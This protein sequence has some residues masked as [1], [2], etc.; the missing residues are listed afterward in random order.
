MAN[1]RRRKM[2]EFERRGVRKA[3]VRARS[4]SVRERTRGGYICACTFKPEPE[5]P[6]PPTSHF[7]LRALQFRSEVSRTESAF[8]ALDRM[9]P[10]HDGRLAQQEGG[11]RRACHSAL[12]ACVDA[13]PTGYDVVAAVIEDVQ[14]ADR[15]AHVARDKLVQTGS[16]RGEEVGTTRV[17][18]FANLPKETEPGK[19]LTSEDGALLRR[20]SVWSFRGSHNARQR[21]A[22]LGAAPRVDVRK[23]GRQTCSGSVDMGGVA[24]HWYV[25]TLAGVLYVLGPSPGVRVRKRQDPVAATIRGGGPHGALVDA[26]SAALRT[27]DNSSVRRTR[28]KRGDGA[29]HR[30]SGGARCVDMGE[31][32]RMKAL[33]EDRD[34][35]RTSSSARRAHA[36]LQI[37]EDGDLRTPLRSEENP[38]QQEC[39]PFLGARTRRRGLSPSL[40]SL[41]GLKRANGR[42]RSGEEGL[43]LESWHRSGRKSR[44]VG[45]SS[46]GNG[47]VHCGGGE[48]RTDW[49]NA[50]RQCRQKKV[51]AHT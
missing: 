14:I 11:W 9:T 33:A 28:S 13:T 26:D 20:G 1:P 19:P 8:R 4:P 45:A 30:R 25:G 38:Q 49:H 34:S 47:I 17:G 7:A 36:A 15:S 39:V 31:D 50:R 51:D 32:E 24:L 3:A 44:G 27:P 40:L 23:T 18:V 43:D 21:S 12:A 48:R 35:A 2:I 29:R 41:V 22:V 5:T 46:N 10:V 42:E 16:A 6:H 37:R